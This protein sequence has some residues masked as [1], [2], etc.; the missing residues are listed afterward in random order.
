VY[1]NPSNLYFWFDFL[2]TEGE[3]GKYSVN[4]IGSRSKVINEPAIKS[5][6]YKETPEV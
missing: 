1:L 5:I 2:D 4:K 3:L 6:Y